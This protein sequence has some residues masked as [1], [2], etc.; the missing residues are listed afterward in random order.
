MT[1]KGQNAQIWVR[2]DKNIVFTVTYTGLSTVA[3][4]TAT[5]V[6]K[7]S[8]SAATNTLS[9]A[10]TLAF[11]STGIFT[12]T[13]TIEDTDTLSLTPATYYHQLD[14]VDAASKRFT[15]SIGSIYLTATGITA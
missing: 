11:V 1:T 10:A 3:G 2:N 5:W 12:A 7:T 15:A 8:V 9:K 6:L 14:I 4:M 13:V